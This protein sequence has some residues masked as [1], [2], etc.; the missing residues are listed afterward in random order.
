M[1]ALSGGAA[2]FGFWFCR[3]GRNF[4]HWVRMCPRLSFVGS[5]VSWGGS[6]GLFV[7]VLDGRSRLDLRGR[8]GER[9]G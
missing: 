6:W 3:L 9:I 2:R 1:D 7:E 5:F 4:F 8:V